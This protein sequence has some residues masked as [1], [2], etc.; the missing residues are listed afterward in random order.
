MWLTGRKK[1]SCCQTPV[2]SEKVLRPVDLIPWPKEEGSQKVAE[3]RD[4]SND[5]GD[6]DDGE[7]SNES[8]NSS[9]G[10]SEEDEE[11]QPVEDDSEHIDGRDFDSRDAAL[12][13]GESK[14][15]LLS[16]SS[17]CAKTA[18]TK[19]KASCAPTHVEDKRRR[20]ET[21]NETD[22]MLKERRPAKDCGRASRVK[23]GSNY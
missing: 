13:S 17:A 22:R 4:G 14:V 19:R 1:C 18:T 12:R 21:C 23:D 3:H 5:D 2:T 16:A 11:V 15:G 20:S 10:G 8:T 6:S 9:L 7:K